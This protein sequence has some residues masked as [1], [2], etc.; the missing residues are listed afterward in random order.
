LRE[1]ASAGGGVSWIERDKILFDEAETLRGQDETLLGGG[2]GPREIK[3]PRHGTRSIS[4]Q[5]SFGAGCDVGDSEKLL[6]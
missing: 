5:R 3:R 2:G 4:L 1:Q 6:G